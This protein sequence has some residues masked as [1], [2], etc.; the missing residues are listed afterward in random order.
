VENE[1]LMVVRTVEELERVK[2]Y[3]LNS[4]FDF[5]A[6]D[7]ETT[8]LEK[9]CELV[10]FSVA[11][12][13]EI[14]I[15]VVLAEWNP[16]NR[17]EDCQ[18]CCGVG[19]LDTGTKKDGTPKKRK[20]CK[21]CKCTGKIQIQ[22]GEL[23]RFPELK[24]ASKQILE[25]LL[26]KR[27]V[28]HNSPF[29]IEVTNREMGVDLMPALHTDTMELWHVLD[30]N[31]YCGLKAIAG[32]LYGDDA[33]E[34]QKLMKASV[35]ANG[36][37]WTE[38]KKAG[39]KKEMHK[40]DIDLFA[41]YGAKDTILTLKIFYDGIPLLF[42]QGLDDFFYNKESMPLMKTAT[43][44]LNTVGL[45]VD[46]DRMKQLEAEMADTCTRLKREVEELIAPDTKEKYPNG[47][48]SKPGQF[49]IGA[50]QQIAWLLFE[51]QAE[52]F[53]VLT[54]GGKALAKEWGKVPYDNRAK[55]EFIQNCRDLGKDPWKYMKADGEILE[56][57][58]KRHAW[59]GKLLDFRA[60][61][62]LL[63]TY[64][65]GIRTRMSYGVVYPSF[66]QHGTTS[67]RY[68]SSN[69]NFQNLPREDKRVKSM[70]VA[71]PGRVFVGADQ[72]Q[73]EPRV[74]ASVSQ[75]ERLMS[76]FAR[77]E[78]F[79]AVIG[80][81]LYADWVADW[82]YHHPG[83]KVGL[84]KKHPN[85]LGADHMNPEARQ[86]SKAFCLASPYGTGAYQQSQK[87]K[88][89]QKWCQEQIDTYFEKFPAV[90]AMM[91]ESHEIAKRDGVVFNL[92]GRPRRIPDAKNINKIYGNLPHN[93]LPYE[94]RTI[95]NLSMNHRVQSTAATIMNRAAIAFTM[96]MRELG[97]DAKILM[98]IHDEIVVECRE[99]DAGTVEK[100][101]KYAMEE[102][103]ILPG[104]VLQAEPKVAKRLS[105]LK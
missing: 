57:Y 22:D 82:E 9:D 55:R 79:Y 92:Y 3:L 31:D 54:D 102:T 86:V 27:L 58:A 4:E 49:N 76:S 71:R 13:L 39:N 2:D 96:K 95:L 19:T 36:G 87:L 97:L 80:V 103:T 7:T 14:G 18:V 101:L 44:D 17:E 23:I 63:K 89:P 56:E 10:G 69:P 83:Q 45:K 5:V 33:T 73:L 93:E 60:E 37:I 78:D 99:E 15:Y 50:P 38:S 35:I 41:R 26:S 6:Y 66:L 81:E 24:E 1:I 68:S 40:A 21:E 98:Q 8:G 42:D 62:K 43:Y 64:V 90:E 100:E 51:K 52:M 65:Q 11:A 94:A 72:S 53:G 104:V 74:F 70:I 12:E 67:G 84:T 47:F 61:L 29:D 88:K 46:L 105:E 30:E 16:N 85:F 28:M 48:G 32:R 34:E 25:I 91:L 59:C 77:G 20:Q 75:D